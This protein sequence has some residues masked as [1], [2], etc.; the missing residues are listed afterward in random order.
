MRTSRKFFACLLIACGCAQA[1]WVQQKSGTDADLA[2]IATPDS[3]TAFA[4]GRDG[5]ILKTTDSGVMWVILPLPELF[6]HPW[7]ATSFSDRWSGTVVGDFGRVAITTDGGEHWSWHTIPGGRTCLCVLHEGPASIY[8]GD[9][10]GWVHLSHDTGNTWSSERVSTWPIR[11]LF[12]WRGYSG[13][14]IAHYALTPYSICENDIF[15][16]YRW[17]ETILQAFQGLGSEAFRG[18]F[19][20]G[21][22]PG[23]L[24]GVHG[25][26]RAAPAIVR[27]SMS[28]TVWRP[29]ATPFSWSGTLFGVSAPSGKTVYVCGEHGLIFNSTDGGDTWSAP[30]VPTTHRLKS[31]CFFDEKRGYAVGDSGTILYTSN[32]G[33]TAIDERDDVQVMGFTLFQNYPNPFN[34]STSIRYALR[35]R[36]HVTLTVFDILGQR[37]AELVNGDIDAGYHEVKFD[38][39][40]LA[41]G[42]YF[43]RLTAGLFVDTKRLLLIH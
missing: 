34:P 9:D 41:S 23:F 18:E 31:I 14:G 2:D 42:V 21:G 15:P 20:N 35:H 24:V 30:S 36:S 3:T 11:S 7:N 29:L 22:G 39:T 10:S 40:N 4:V 8:V 27:K 26:L 5:S 17:T 25:D 32:G 6:F 13:M 33:V 37:V 28:D 12:R 43:Y 38:A 19:S 1:Q 16:L